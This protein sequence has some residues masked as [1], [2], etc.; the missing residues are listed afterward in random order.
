MQMV[1]F[2]PKQN[3]ERSN[4][5]ILLGIS[6]WKCFVKKGIL[7]CNFIKRDFKKAFSC[8]IYETFNNTFFEE[9]L[10]MTPNL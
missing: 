5:K 7:A 4:T 10:R 6:H 3:R 9:N 2:D 1:C 8:E